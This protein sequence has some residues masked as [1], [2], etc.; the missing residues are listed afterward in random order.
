[1]SKND[2]LLT[3]EKNMVNFFFNFPR[4][5]DFDNPFLDLFALFDD[6][7]FNDNE[8]FKSANNEFYNNWL[9]YTLMKNIF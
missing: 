7:S 9:P 5:N 1:M 3:N 6:L 8:F 2:L 4:N